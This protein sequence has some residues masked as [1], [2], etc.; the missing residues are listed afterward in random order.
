MS[1]AGKWDSM[2]T[3][4]SLMLAFGLCLAGCASSDT[5]SLLASDGQQAI[6]R[7]G[8]PSLI[9]AKKNVVMLQSGG[10]EF[11]SGLRPRFVVALLNMQPDMVEFSPAGITAKAVGVTGTSTPLK[12]FS[13][14]ELVAEEKRRQT[15]AAIGAVLAGAA[16]GIN[17]ANA[18]YSNTMSIYSGNSTTFIAGDYSVT[19]IAIRRGSGGVIVTFSPYLS[20]TT[21]K[22]LGWVLSKKGPTND[23]RRS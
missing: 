15:V 10:E 22:V 14:A 19:L 9:S 16:R 12:V 8:A 13:Y 23:T 5:V 7:N 20:R 6:T 2:Q 11:S 17:A 18:G 3:R 4:L 21:T 1:P